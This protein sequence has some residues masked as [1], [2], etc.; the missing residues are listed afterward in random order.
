MKIDT[1]AKLQCAQH[2]FAIA[3]LRAAIKVEEARLDLLKA[4]LDHALNNRSS[5]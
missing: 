2:D 5:D 3:E 1:E 4:K